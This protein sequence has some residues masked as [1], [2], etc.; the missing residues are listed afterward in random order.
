MALDPAISTALK[1]S[2]PL[3]GLRSLVLD[4]QAQG[5]DQAAILTLLEQSRSEL[6][7]SGR[8]REEDLIL[9]VM[10]LVVG[11]CSPHMALTPKPGASGV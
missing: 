6:S 5:Q 7:E 1:S 10:D 9:D 3:N 4:L 2:D 8:E 11:W